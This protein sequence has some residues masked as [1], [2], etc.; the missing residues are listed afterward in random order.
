[1]TKVPLLAATTLVLAWSSVEGQR[2][3]ICPSSVDDTQIVEA[4]YRYQLQES[5]KEKR[6]NLF[7]IAFGSPEIDEAC[8]ERWADL[9]KDH[10][11]PVKKFARNG[12]EAE[13]MKKENGLVLGVGSIKRKSEIDA[14]VEGYIF[15]VPG[16]AQ[17][18]SYFLIRENGKWIVK[19]SKGAWT[20]FFK[21]N[22][23]RQEVI[24]TM[25][26]RHR[27][28]PLGHARRC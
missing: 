8:S 27:P 28:A 2:R 4:V 1:M 19:A 9:F 23:K 12:F 5:V 22:Q 16:E 6:W 17:G 15:V 21:G 10:T 24:A 18:Y 20:A 26:V 25:V 3:D 14:E 11:P 7:Y 13:R